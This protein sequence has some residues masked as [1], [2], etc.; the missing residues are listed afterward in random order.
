MTVP[1]PGNLTRVL[2]SQEIAL[3][4]HLPQG[5]LVIDVPCSR[6]SEADGLL[7]VIAC[8]SFWLYVLSSSMRTGWVYKWDVGPSDLAGAVY[9]T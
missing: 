8:R 5:D 1:R 6:V 3:Y 2:G 4:Q 9:A 7:L